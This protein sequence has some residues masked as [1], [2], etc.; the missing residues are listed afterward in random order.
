M[1]SP[2][3]DQ[4]SKARTSARQFGD[5]TTYALDFDIGG[6]NY[7]FIPEDVSS[8]G[9]ITAGDNTYLLP[10]F[11][12]VENQKQFNEN[13]SSIDLSSLG[14]AKY[15]EGQGRSTKGYLAPSSAISIDSEIGRAHV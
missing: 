8:K 1:A 6:Q 3:L 13:T 11:T 12:S 2:T 15:L 9:G 14:L 7:V 4:I 10:Y 5:G